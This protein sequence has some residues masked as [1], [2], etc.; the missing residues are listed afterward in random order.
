MSPANVEPLIQCFAGCGNDK[1]ANMRDICGRA[2]RLC[3]RASVNQAVRGGCI[4][5]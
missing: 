4:G 2:A 3:E 1:P 5:R